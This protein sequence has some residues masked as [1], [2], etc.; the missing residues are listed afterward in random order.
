MFIFDDGD[1]KRKVLFF[2]FMIFEMNL[3]AGVTGQQRMLTPS[4]HLNLPSHLS[5]V[6]A[7]LHSIL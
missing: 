4:Q 6:H 3:M 5:E 7:A 2:I 1:Y